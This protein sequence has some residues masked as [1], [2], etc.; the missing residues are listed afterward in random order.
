MKSYKLFVRVLPKTD[1]LNINY[2]IFLIS[3]TVSNLSNFSKYY[4]NI[5]IFTLH[6]L[7]MSSSPF[8]FY[9]QFLKKPKEKD[10]NIRR[11]IL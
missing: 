10:I 7:N 4:V 3:D 5:A 2:Y 1:E 9:I 8:I 6:Y 11:L